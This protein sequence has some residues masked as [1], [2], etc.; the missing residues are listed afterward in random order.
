MS[1][2][3][4]T[5]GPAGPTGATGETGPSFSGVTGAVLFYDGSAVTGNSSL[6]YDGS[7]NLTNQNSGN[8]IDLDGMG[9]IVVGISETD[10]GKVI[11]LGSGNAYI[12]ISD[13]NTG[14]ESTIPS[15]ILLTTTLLD[16][17]IDGAYGSDGQYLGSNGA[18]HVVWSTPPTNTGPTGATGVTGSQIL[19]GSIVP[20]LTAGAVNDTYI[21]T[22][23]GDVYSKTSS[24]EWNPTSSS[25]LVWK[26]VASD[27]TGQ[28]LTACVS[29]GKI[30]TSDNAG[31]IWTETSASTEDWSS[32]TSDSSG[33]NLAACA[34][35]GG[36]YYSLNYG[37]TWTAS[38][39]PVS[40]WSSIASNSSGD[41]L[42]ACISGGGIYYS[43]NYGTNWTASTALNQSWTSVAS[44]FGA[45]NLV[46]S[47]DSGRIWTSSDSGATWT[48]TNAPISSWTSVTSNSTGQFL[49]ACTNYGTIWTSDTAGVSW[50][51]TGSPP[52]SWT[53]V[54]CT[55]DES[56]LIACSD[57]SGIY[58]SIDAGATWTPSDA[59]NFETWTSV[60]TDSTGTKLVA[61][62]TNEPIYTTS[63]NWTL[64]LNITGPTGSAPQVYQ[65]T[66]YKSANQNLT[67]GATDIT[68]DSTGE[69]NNPGTYISH[70][71]GTTD[72]TVGVTGLYQMEFN[73]FIN[74]NGA[75]WNLLTNKNV[76]IDITRTPTAEQ[77]VIAN[78][79]LQAN[80]GG[81]GGGVG[82]NY[83]QCV[84]ATYYLKVGDVI[85]LRVANTF[86]GGPPSAEGL[87]NTFDLNTFF[88]W[89]FI[90]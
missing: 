8:Y 74:A 14:G 62:A 22:T 53:S 29:N 26:S 90:S 75:S 72:F 2:E 34:Y 7:H 46:A 24:T 40:N 69:W 41:K 39:A 80:A 36:I 49:A 68:F 47:V 59:P 79:A 54:K 86:T 60:T 32:I 42:V 48:E 16:V 44:D 70:T 37:G 76:A 71:N 63:G 57:G 19:Y 20:G 87:L 13:Q 11:S 65:A 45:N 12:N 6:T 85:N 84:T 43:I 50:T 15:S 18:G 10:V 38:D 58:T 61:C 23:N 33:G 52:N 81:G 31:G 35:A 73:A 30:W 89:R 64:E 77:A 88:T 3:G 21:N 66:Y 56:K 25:S 51:E 1:Y 9:G 78:T 27:S 17:N 82:V 28:L 5:P 4:G 55:P 83:A 67:S